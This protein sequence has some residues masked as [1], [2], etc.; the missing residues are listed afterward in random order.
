L[1]LKIVLMVQDAL[2]ARVAPQVVVSAKKFAPEPVMAMFERVSG[3][4]PESVR[5]TV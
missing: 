5:V 1:G 2:T 4:V 3:A